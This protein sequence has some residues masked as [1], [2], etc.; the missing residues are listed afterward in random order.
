MV[1]E[2]YTVSK[3]PASSFCRKPPPVSCGMLS[4]YFGIADPPAAFTPYTA[5]VLLSPAAN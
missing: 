5:P 1:N 2:Y 4:T 3:A